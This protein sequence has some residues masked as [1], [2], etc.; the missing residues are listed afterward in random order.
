[1]ATLPAKTGVNAGCMWQAAAVLYPICYHHQIAKTL[2][3]NHTKLRLYVH[4]Q[5]AVSFLP[6]TSDGFSALGLTDAL[7]SH[8]KCTVEM[9]HQEREGDCWNNAVA[10][11]SFGIIKT[12][13]VYHDQY[14]DHQDALH[15]IFEYMEVFYNR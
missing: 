4:E 5:Q 2:H 6:T 3:L 1:M 15:A 10:E 14:K 9:Q 11:S 7:I 13:L 8:Y 12:E